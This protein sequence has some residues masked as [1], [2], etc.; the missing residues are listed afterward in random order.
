MVPENEVFYAPY[1][2]ELGT[3]KTA[4]STLPMGPN[5]A[6]EEAHKAWEEVAIA[7]DPKN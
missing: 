4:D 1:E 3:L 7:N 6:K 2:T 5:K